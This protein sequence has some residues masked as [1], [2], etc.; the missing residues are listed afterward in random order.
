MIAVKRPIIEPWQICDFSNGDKSL[1]EFYCKV[2]GI[3]ATVVSLINSHGGAVREL[4][5]KTNRISL[6]KKCGILVSLNSVSF[7]LG[8][9]PLSDCHE[10]SPAP[11]SA[12]LRHGPRSYFCS[13]C[14][15]G[16]E[17]TVAPRVNR[18]LAPTH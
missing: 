5:N 6:W 4:P 12:C 18:S 17:S 7:I 2:L 15:N 16:G 10:W 11:I 13:E 9:C 3:V 1:H 14:C 8:F